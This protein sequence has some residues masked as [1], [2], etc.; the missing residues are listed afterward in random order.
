[1][2]H[3]LECYERA[4]LELYQLSIKSIHMACYCCSS[5]SDVNIYGS[6]EKYITKFINKYHLN[7]LSDLLPADDLHC[8]ALLVV[9]DTPGSIPGL[10]SNI[11]TQSQ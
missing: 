11:S 7:N 8:L 9:P 10:H 1:M 3:E 2:L 6:W 4:P 5:V